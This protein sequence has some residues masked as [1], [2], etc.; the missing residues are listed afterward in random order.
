VPEKS[1]ELPPEEVMP[2]L[3]RHA[4][5]VL[6]GRTGIVRTLLFE[7]PSASTDS[8]VAADWTFFCGIARVAQYVAEPMRLGRLRPMDPLWR[9]RAVNGPV[10]LRLL[11]GQY[12]SASWGTTCESKKV[13]IQLADNWGRAMRPGKLTEPGAAQPALQA[14]RA[15]APA[16]CPDPGRRTR[17]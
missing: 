6:K 5:L 7:L 9:C 15:T 11:T 8:R 16:V 10:L 14:V 4:A 17:R 2:Q 12:W 3:A 13:V 1:G